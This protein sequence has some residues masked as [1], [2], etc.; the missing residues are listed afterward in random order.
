MT[1][2]KCKESEIDPK[3][4]KSEQVWCLLSK[5]TGRVLGRH[6]SK[7]KALKQEQAIQISKHAD[8]QT[9]T[10]TNNLVK[11]VTITEEI[12]DTPGSSAPKEPE[13]KDVPTK[14]EESK[15]EVPESKPKEVS[16]TI[17]PSDISN[18]TQLLQQV[19]KSEL[20]E[21]KPI[22]YSEPNVPDSSNLNPP[23]EK[24]EVLSIEQQKAIIQFSAKDKL[25][26]ILDTNGEWFPLLEI[27]PEEYKNHFFER[28]RSLA[29]SDPKVL[30][31]M[32]AVFIQSKV[33]LPHLQ[34]A[35]SSVWDP[36]TLEAGSDYL[37]E[38]GFVENPTV[39]IN[40]HAEATLK[41]HRRLAS[42]ARR[43]RLM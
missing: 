43:L 7:D 37:H 14:I 19:L 32:A 13:T 15:E 36:E 33:S 26:G 12:Y 3:R 5:K 23:P 17:T 42:A 25:W 34:L 24:F 10:E 38:N 8:T 16:N 41:R 31:E 29:I 1:I 4:P 20:P 2:R 11:K 21:P 18:L 28:M 39:Q 9:V 30:K 22:E 27:L 6:S 40:L 35:I